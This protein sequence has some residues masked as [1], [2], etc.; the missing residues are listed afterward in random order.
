VDF[1]DPARSAILR[2]V[3]TLERNRRWI[4]KD[5]LLD[6]SLFLAGFLSVAPQV[7][8]ARFGIGFETFAVAR[9]L[10]QQGQYANP[11]LTATGPSALLPPLYPIFLA[12]L[13]KVFAPAAA[14][15]T[16]LTLCHMF[17]HALHAALLPRLSELFFRDRLPGICA[18]FVVILLPV[19]YFFPHSESIFCPIGVMLFCLA[20]DRRLPRGGAGGA[21]FTGLFAGLLV[22]LNPACV[23]LCA[24]WLIYLWW[25][26]RVAFVRRSAVL[27]ALA[28]VMT[29]APWT[30]RNYQQFHSVFFVRDNL[31]LELYISNND[32]AQPDIVRNFP[33]GMRYFHPGGSPAEADAVRD[34]GEVEYTHQRLAAALRWI[35]GHPGRFLKLTLLRIGLFWFPDADGFT[36]VH[37]YAVAFVNLGAFFGIVLLLRRRVPIAKFLLAVMALFPLLY[38]FVQVDTRYRTPI[39]WLNLLGAGYLITAVVTAVFPEPVAPLET[40]IPQL[41]LLD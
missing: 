8:N 12:M 41:H 40:T 35:A 37:G 13:M 1:P 23:I 27:I 19:I 16:A 29:L 38:Y 24:L 15:A 2:E 17:A 21:L 25:T 32:V 39:L 28:F 7:H 18:A 11:F 34:L 26:H 31:G 9:N 36:Q 14:F 22:L 6:I 4:S 10:V 3:M 30:W 20:T 5:R 33:T